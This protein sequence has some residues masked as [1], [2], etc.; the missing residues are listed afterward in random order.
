MSV[1]RRDSSSATNCQ[2][3]AGFGKLITRSGLRKEG[4]D[5]DSDEM[6]GL[7]FWTPDCA[8]TLVDYLCYPAISKLRSS[9]FA[10]VFCSSQA[11]ATRSFYV[12][13]IGKT[14][15]HERIP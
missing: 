5:D 8:S 15:T 3:R 7:R 6:D 12:K 13:A 9:G 10:G 14:K 1:L 2:Q 11:P 4:R